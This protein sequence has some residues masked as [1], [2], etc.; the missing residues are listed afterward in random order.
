MSEQT[1]KSNDRRYHLSNDDRSL[2]IDLY[3]TGFDP[4]EIAEQFNITTKEVKDLAKR[5]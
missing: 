4:K 1:N 2:I 5:G 3:R